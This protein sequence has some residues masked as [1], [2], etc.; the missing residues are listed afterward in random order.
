MHLLHDGL[1]RI[2]V[3]GCAAW[4]LA[5]VPGLVAAQIPGPD[6]DLPSRTPATQS[7]AGGSVG[8]E[9]GAGS[10]QREA[11]RS[12]PAFEPRIT[13]QHTI[14]NNS[15]LI[16][17]GPGDQM[18]EVMPGFR[19]IRDT[20]RFKGFVDYTLRA[21][22]YARDTA[23][24]KIWHNLF[25]KGTVEAV[26]DVLFVDV[27]G[28]SSL[29]SISAFGPAGGG[30]P[31]NSNLTQTTSFRVSP[32]VKG[33]IGDGVSYEARYGIT[34]TRYDS[35][36]RSDVTV[37]DWSLR[38]GK[39]PVG[40]LWS[41]GVDATEQ[42][43][44]Y[45]NGRSIDTTSLR[46]HLGYMPV[47][48]LRLTGIAGVESTNQLSPTRQSNS[49]FGF[50]IDW[51]PSDRASFRFDR[52]KRY[53]GESHNAVAQYRTARTV[54]RYTDSRSI[55]NGLGSQHGSPG[56]LFD[57]LDGFYMRSEPNAIRRM[58]LV[59]DE[60]ARLGL[61]ADMRV[62]QDF[63]TSSS[64]LQRLQNLS[65][66]ILGQR[67]TLTMSVMRSNSRLLQSAVQLGDDFDND[68]KIRQR[69]WNIALS[70]RLTPSSSITA[71]YGETR[72]LGVDSG[73]ET[74]TRPFIVAWTHLVTRSTNVG[75]QLR[76]VLS[77][78][79]VSRYGESAIMG[80]ITHRF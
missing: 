67:S 3:L 64:N 41:W 57:L 17:N 26:E 39:Q 36:A 77:D 54:W 51:R 70:H 21:A 53:F 18:T 8:T 43:V 23:A 65:F 44:D 55:V 28:Q 30:N 50:G 42:N 63:L 15:R 24:D 46:G 6:V 10:D 59:Q 38:L 80:S 27:D 9:Q 52:E 74:R 11:G 19:F 47:S 58:Q 35:A 48:Q 12:G 69:G 40:Q 61:P 20:A 16:S 73:L 2:P 1:A 56:S 71:S 76:R 7:P 29:Q 66:A 68:N 4:V 72:S 5:S 31:A 14:T 78:G 60:I 37:N 62:F 25:A 33:D 49:I 34:D 22:N 79:N 32:Y 45:S 13:I 75:I